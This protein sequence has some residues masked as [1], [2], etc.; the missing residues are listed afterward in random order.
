MKT[1]LLTTKK[2]KYL[3]FVTVQVLMK[4]FLLHAF[5]LHLILYYVNQ[6][7]HLCRFH[8][9]FI[10]VF[11]A[12]DIIFAHHIICADY[13]ILLFQTAAKSPETHLR[14]FGVH[15]AQHTSS[16]LLIMWS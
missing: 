9:F 7:I 6:F 16:I 8:T 1:F 13:I 12:N 3:K 14:A 10:S 11:C 2:I 5:I 4:T 15:S